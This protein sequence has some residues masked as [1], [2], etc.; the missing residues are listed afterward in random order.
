MF[1]FLLCLSS[2][3]YKQKGIKGFKQGEVMDLYTTYLNFIKRH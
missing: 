3:E 1:G 2:K